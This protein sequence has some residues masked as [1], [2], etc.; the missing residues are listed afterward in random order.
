MYSKIISESIKISHRNTALKSTCSLHLSNTN[1]FA[2]L[3]TKRLLHSHTNTVQGSAMLV[4]SFK[5][6]HK[7]H[8]LVKSF[9]MYV[10]H[11]VQI[12]LAPCPNYK[13]E[14]DSPYC[15]EAVAVR[16]GRDVYMV[17][18]KN[19]DINFKMCDDRVLHDAVRRDGG[20]TF[21]VCII[22][23]KNKSNYLL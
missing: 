9:Y 8:S 20:K 7:R 17:D 1:S 16:A 14:R 19:N 13:S 3:Q 5:F 4:L 18:I 15:N 2:V 23:H 10:L 6:I 11:Q 22:R 12:R 21:R